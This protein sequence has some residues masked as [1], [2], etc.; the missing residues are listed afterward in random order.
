VEYDRLAYAALLAAFSTW[1][2]G[3]KT[4]A[5][6][7]VGGG[8]GNTGSTMGAGGA[9]AGGGP[10]A[11]QGVAVGAGGFGEG[12]GVGV[13]GG[14]GAGGFGG[15]GVTYCDPA[16]AYP[17]PI[18]PIGPMISDFETG[19]GVQAVRP[20]G[21]WTPT[22]D[23]TGTSTINVEPCGLSGMG[24][25]FTGTGH[26]AWGAI[27]GAALANITQPVNASAYRGVSFLVRARTST[28]IIV[29]VEN[30]YSQP[31]CGKCEDLVAGAECYA[32]YIKTLGLPAQVILPVI[33]T[34]GDFS[35]QSWGYHAPGTALFDPRNLVT[36]SF[37]FDK[38][39]D[40]D[41]CIDDV[42]FVP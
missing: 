3:G 33:V 40:F 28:S 41:V 14:P 11:G 38:S 30:P 42:V 26:T 20:G 29:K 1:S 16:H 13:G 36:L 2:C 8:G 21:T 5:D 31:A 24:L 15:L 7:G 17:E 10:G 39:V 34:W 9:S 19:P 37:A 18:L 27:V 6:A 25:H 12:I 23:G 4:V 35:Q 22:S 32:G